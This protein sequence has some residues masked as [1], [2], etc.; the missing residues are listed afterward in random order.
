MKSDK[1]VDLVIPTICGLLLVLMVSFFFLQIFLREIF[2]ISL[3]WTDQTSQF[4]MTW[5]T[6]LGSIWC[7]KNNQQLNTGLK[8]HKKLNNKMVGLI[9]GILAIFIAAIVA[10]VVYQS[11]IHAFVSM[12]TES[13]ALPWFKMGYVY[14]ALPLAMLATCYYYLK[15]FLKNFAR[16]FKKD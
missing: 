5:L 6:F 13:L 12:N 8:L 15:S 2:N 9:D 11:V 16:V 4:C 7:D 3:S 14:I 10:V 1:V